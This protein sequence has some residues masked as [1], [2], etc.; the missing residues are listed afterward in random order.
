MLVTVMGYRFNWFF[1]FLK[2]LRLPLYFSAFDR[3]K[4]LYA[5]NRTTVKELSHSN[6]TYFL[7]IRIFFC[8][9]NHRLNLLFFTAKFPLGL[10]STQAHEIINL[11]KVFLIYRWISGIDKQEKTDVHYRLVIDKTKQFHIGT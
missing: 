7:I 3:G 2:C 9:E 10:I 11:H 6:R 5:E 8:E 1:F 4:F